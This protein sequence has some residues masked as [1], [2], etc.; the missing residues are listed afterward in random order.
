MSRRSQPESTLLP[1]AENL[2]WAHCTSFDELVAALTAD[3]AEYRLLLAFLGV[4]RA[5]HRRGDDELQAL[6]VIDRPLPALPDLGHL[7]ALAQEARAEPWEYVL[8]GPLRQ[9]DGS[10]ADAEEAALH[11]QHL[12]LRVMEGRQLGGY[13]AFERGGRRVTAGP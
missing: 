7:Q 9:P 2:P 11:L 8:V 4:A 1:I 12:A 6:L 5:G 10:L 13:L 3:R